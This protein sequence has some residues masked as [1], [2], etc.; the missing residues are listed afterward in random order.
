MKLMVSGATTTV[1]D[2][3]GDP[4]V[5]PYLGALVTPNTSNSIARV[6]NWG[7]PWAVDAGCFPR[8]VFCPARYMATIVRVAEAEEPPVFVVVPDVVPMTPEG[9][10]GDHDE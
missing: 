2:L 10:V 1:E 6:T 8:D 3:L 5:V 4:D 9:P 7:L